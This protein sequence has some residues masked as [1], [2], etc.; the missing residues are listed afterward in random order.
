MVYRRFG[1]VFSR[2][3]LNKQD[4]LGELENTLREMDQDDASNGRGRCLMSR[5]IDNARPAQNRPEPRQKLLERM[6]KKAIEYSEFRVPLP[7][8]EFYI[9]QSTQVT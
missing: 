9:E 5:T 3:L 4:E 7:L 2:L 1:S 6:E 8:D